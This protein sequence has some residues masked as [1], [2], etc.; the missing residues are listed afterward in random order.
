LK[1]VLVLIVVLANPPN[2]SS[3]YPLALLLQSFFAY[4]GSNSML[5]PGLPISDVLS[6]IGPGEGALPL[7][8]VIQKLSLVLLTIFPG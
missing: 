5:F 6:A 1:I 7:A 4:V 2:F 3:V 8:L